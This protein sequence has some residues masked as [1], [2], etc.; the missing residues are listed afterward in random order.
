MAYGEVD[1]GFGIV[2]WSVSSLVMLGDLDRLA[3]S[4]HIKSALGSLAS[5]IT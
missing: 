5:Y 2:R 4:M 1:K 3:R